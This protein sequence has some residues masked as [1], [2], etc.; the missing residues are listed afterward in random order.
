MY[1]GGAGIQ[2]VMKDKETMDFIKSISSDCG[3]VSSVC[4]G[5][6]VLGSAG[7]LQDK[8]ATTHWAYQHLLPLVGAKPSDAR[9]VR[10]GNVFTGGGV[11]SGIDFAINFIE[12]IY[13]QKTAD[14]I[15]LALQYDQNVLSKDR[16]DKQESSKEILASYKT[17]ADSL[18]TFL[19][20]H[21]DKS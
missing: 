8:E 12:E 10:D 16:L 5:A 7:L 6:F 14:N 4:T 17:R 21:K 2:D 9:F 13:D 3:Y 1:T 15:K 20:E 19:I 11:T 18:E